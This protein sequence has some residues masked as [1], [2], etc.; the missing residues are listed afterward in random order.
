MVMVMTMVKRLNGDKVD[1]LTL[2]LKDKLGHRYHEIKLHGR[3]GS[4]VQ[5]GSMGL[6]F[7]WTRENRTHQVNTDGS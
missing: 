2:K 1:K 6:I 5:A 3:I 7:S 4:G